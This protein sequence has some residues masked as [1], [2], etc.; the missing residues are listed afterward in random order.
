MKKK[1]INLRYLYISKSTRVKEWENDNFKNIKEKEWKWYENQIAKN[2]SIL[3]GE[4]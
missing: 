4:Y 3:M 2:K 1:Y